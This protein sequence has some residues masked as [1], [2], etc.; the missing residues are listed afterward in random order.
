MTWPASSVVH[1]MRQIA[2][3]KELNDTAVKPPPLEHVT[4]SAW[5]YVILCRGVFPLFCLETQL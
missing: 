3:E 1:G 4:P 5:I 2:N